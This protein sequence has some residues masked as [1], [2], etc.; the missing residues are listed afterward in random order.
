MSL[1]WSMCSIRD[2]ATERRGIAESV[3]NL[4]VDSVD[5]YNHGF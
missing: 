5:T 4:V 3:Y 1:A 2:E